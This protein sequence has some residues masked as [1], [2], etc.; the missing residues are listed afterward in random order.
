MANKNLTIIAYNAKGTGKYADGGG[1]YV[2]V[3][4]GA[5]LRFS[6]RYMLGGKAR[7]MGL[8][9][10]NESSLSDVRKIAKDLKASLRCGIDPLEQKIANKEAS[11]AVRH[12]REKQ[13]VLDGATFDKVRD[14][15]LLMK[16]GEWKNAKHRQQWTSTLDKYAA[17]FIGLKAVNKISQK[18]LLAILKPHW[19]TKTETIT[20]VRQRIEAVLD[21][22]ISRGYREAPNPA[23]W[24]SSLKGLLPNPAKIKTVKHFASL[25]YKELPEF[26]AKLSTGEAVSQQAMRFLILTCTRTSETLGA[27]WSEIDFE[28]ALWV[29]PAER[30][31]AGVE[32][33]IPL[34]SPALELLESLPRDGVYL[35]KG[36]RKGRPLSQTSMLMTLRRMK[37]DSITT[38]GFRSTFRTWV[39][40]KTQ[41]PDRLAEIS[42]AHQ[43]KDKVE[44]S[45]LRTDQISKRRQLLEDWA[46]FCDQPPASKNVI[47]IERK[48]KQSE[49]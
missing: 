41:H 7:E 26:M 39:S 46:R 24:K 17:P 49:R 43:L 18:D 21:F 19:E 38:H 4:D 13:L 15:F 37:F 31:K 29:I 9:T 44:A 40:E 3:R 10:L 6:F 48:I 1:L 2:E 30:M 32:H 22:S 8:G 25:P 20:R 12:E 11:L 14:E 23:A 28:Q 33:R 5:P 47:N 36:G 34:T 42:L 16:Q 35:F 45:Y 27:V